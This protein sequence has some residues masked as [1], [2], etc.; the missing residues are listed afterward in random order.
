MDVLIALQ[1]SVGR[2][3]DAGDPVLGKD[4]HLWQWLASD[5]DR[6]GIVSQEDA[7]AILLEAVG[8]PQ[9]GAPEF[10]FVPSDADMVGLASN[11]QAYQG[12]KIFDAA[13]QI[14]SNWIGVLLGDGDGSWRSIVG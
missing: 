4:R 10:L 8:D 11:P 2:Q 7:R 13:P 5:I 1:L 12:V 14:E 6:D 9:A 3:P